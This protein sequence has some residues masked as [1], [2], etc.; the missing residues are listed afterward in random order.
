MAHIYL[1][2]CGAL[3]CFEEEVG[4]MFTIAGVLVLVANFL[5][6]LRRPFGAFGI[7]GALL[8]PVEE[9]VGDLVLFVFGTLVL[10]GALVLRFDVGVAILVFGALVLLGLMSVLTTSL[11]TRPRPCR[12]S[13][14]VSCC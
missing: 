8:L 2:A 10:C 7:V 4:V 12:L 6:T 14:S 13:L 9:V 5:V 3:V 1:L 11:G